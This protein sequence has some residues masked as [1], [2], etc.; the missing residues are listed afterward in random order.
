MTIAAIALKRY[1]L[2]TG[3]YPTDLSALVPEFL[4]EKPHDWMNGEPLRYRLNADGTFTLYSVGE[5]GMDDGGDPNP[6]QG[7]RLITI[8]DGRDAVWPTA[9]PPE[10][11]AN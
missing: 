11:G 3:K 7:K 4:P 10:S 1:Q 6:T 2:R 8:W 9:A 5:N